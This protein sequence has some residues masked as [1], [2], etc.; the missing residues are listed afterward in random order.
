MVRLEFKR[1][2]GSVLLISEGGLK[3]QKVGVRPRANE[4]CGY[5]TTNG[6]RNSAG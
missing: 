5:T 2:K 1:L 6:S 4:L 3:G